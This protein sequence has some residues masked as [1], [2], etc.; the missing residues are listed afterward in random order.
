MEDGAMLWWGQREVRGDGGAQVE[1][2]NGG[3]P[4]PSPSWMESWGWFRAMMAP[5]TVWG[6]QDG[7]SWA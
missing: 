2:K 5:G 4:Q 6:D 1:M 7:W 3:L